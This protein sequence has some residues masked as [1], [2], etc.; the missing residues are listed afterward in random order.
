MLDSNPTL[1]YRADIDGLRAIAVLDVLFFHLKVLKVWGGFIGVDVFFVISGFLISSVILREIGES[2]FSLS[3]FYQRR[4]RRILPVSVAMM[5]AAAV[6]GYFFLLPPELVSF[7]GSLLAAVLSASNV[8]FWLHSGYFDVSAADQ[9]LLHTWSLAVEEQFYIA[10]PLLLLFVRRYFPQRLKSAI[11][12][13]ACG[14]FAISA[15]GAYRFPSATFYLPF[16]RAWELLLGTMLSLHLFPSIT[17]KLWRNVASGAGL[18]L[19]VF[20]SLKFDVSTPF[21]GIAALA[22]CLGA[23]MIIAA[24]QNGGSFVGALLSTRPFV[25]IGLISYSLYIW[26]WPIV[27]FQRTGMVQFPGASSRSVKSAIFIVCLFVAALSW[28]YIELPFR[29]GRLNLSGA[30]TFRFA[31]ASSLGLVAVSI[32]ILGFHGFPKRYSPEELLI[33][34]YAKDPTSYRIGS[35][36]IASGNNP[37][38]FDIKSCMRQD[39]TMRNYLLF[40]DSHAAQLWYGLTKAYPN[41]NFLEATSSGCEPTVHHR[42]FDTRRCNAIMDYVFDDYLQTHTC[43]QLILAARW[44]LDDMDALGKTIDFLKLRGVRVVLV[45]PIVQ[46]DSPLPRLLAVSLRSGDATLP[47][48]HELIKYRQLDE[49]MAK[50]AYDRWKV[51][52]IS[53]FEL[54]CPQG[55]CVQ[56]AG[57][58]IPLQFDYGHLTTEGSWLVGQRLRE[59]GKLDVVQPFIAKEQLA[60]E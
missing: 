21:P 58:D 59:S 26:H 10:F 15:V 31:A 36:F 29:K 56:Y 49:K 12:L 50:L 4:I 7:G 38:D 11:V 17:T 2:R 5:L 45:G 44:E 52:Y 27:V 35:C 43:D 30:F 3:S 33:A 57:K 23:A 60:R 54:L 46:Y 51:Q 13:I 28:K 19:I 20:A 55:I 9:P 40:G 48:R 34:S 37:R 14:T 42:V 47:F 16:T 22:P 8:F 53:Y 24:G 25:F 1:A 6:A 41:I 39:K 32:C 18:I